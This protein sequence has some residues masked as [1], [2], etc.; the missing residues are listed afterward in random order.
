MI[1]RSTEGDGIRAFIISSRQG[2]LKSTSLQNREVDLSVAALQVEANETVD[3]VVDIDQVLNNDQFL[4]A[5]V[6]SNLNPVRDAALSWGTEKDFTVKPEQML[7]PLEQLAQV[8]LISNERMF[9]P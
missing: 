1:H 9:V 6:I 7:S 8:L 4:W 5:P 2:I 3:F